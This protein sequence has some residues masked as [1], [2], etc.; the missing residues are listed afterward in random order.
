MALRDR[1]L[2]MVA[3]QLGRP[4][5]ALGRL[6]ARRLN[7]GNRAVVTAAVE[8]ARPAP[9]AAV[10]EV[11]FGGGLGVS[12]LLDRVAPDGVVH[13][14]E[15]SETMLARAGRVFRREVADG[16]LQLH[17]ATMDRLPQPDGS[18]DAVVSTN[19]IYFVDDLPAALT[20]IARVLR[21]G[22]RL[23]LG[24]GDP[25]AMARMALTRHGFTLRPVSEVMDE[26]SRAGFTALED[27]R[28]GSDAEAPHVLVA[29]R[30][31]DPTQASRGS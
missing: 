13:G 24:V 6:V 15:I 3:G 22:G 4:S 2:R 21:P 11:G 30:A 18:L 19:T 25:S 29:E 17:R 10:A 8:A 5:G 28:V 16:R 7:R 12:L 23:A 14:V 20:G 31:P 1:A 9:G 26:V 27:H